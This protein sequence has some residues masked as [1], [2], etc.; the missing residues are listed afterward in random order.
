MFQN[1]IILIFFR[2]VTL[3]SSSADSVQVLALSISNFCFRIFVGS[4]LH[5]ESFNFCNSSLLKPAK[6]EL[7]GDF[8]LFGDFDILE[9]E[10]GDLD[11]EFL[12][13]LEDL[14]LDFE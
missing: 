9:I 11:K 5:K 4:S 12:G 7:D 6:L 14:D 1:L 8:G 10:P 2:L 13:D 3:P